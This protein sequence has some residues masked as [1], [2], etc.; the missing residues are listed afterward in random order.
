MD[1]ALVYPQAGCLI[2]LCT[3]A[4]GR[5]AKAHGMTKKRLSL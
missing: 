5:A 2:R 3:A 1:E 4:Q